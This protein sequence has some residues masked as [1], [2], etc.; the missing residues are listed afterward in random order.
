[1]LTFFKNLKWP[2]RFLFA[3]IFG[4]LVYVVISYVPARKYLASKIPTFGDMATVPVLVAPSKAKEL[5]LPSSKPSDKGVPV[6]KMEMKWNSQMSE[7]LANGGERTTVGSSA[8]KFGVNMTLSNETEDTGRMRDEFMT[9][10]TAYAEAREKD[11]KANPQVGTH[12]FT[13]MGSGGAA[14]ASSLWDRMAKIGLHPE[15][16][17][18]SSGKSAGEDK[19]M[20]P[21]KWLDNPQSARGSL[22]AVFPMDGDQD[23]I[24]LWAKMNRIPV[25]TNTKFFDNDAINI[26]EVSDFEIAGKAY[27]T[28]AQ[29][30]RPLIKNG[31]PV[32]GKPETKTVEGF[33]SWTPVDV[34][35]ME[36][37]G[38]VVTLASTATKGFEWQMPN[39]TFG[40][41]E[42]DENHREVIEGWI[43]AVCEAGDQ[44]IKY[45][46]A[47][48]HA[49]KIAA[50]V[51]HAYDGA[52]WEKYYKGYPIKDQGNTIMLGG[53]A[54]F[55]LPMN[56]YMYGL[57]P[58]QR[59]NIYARTYTTFGQLQSEFY[60]DI[61][62]SFP[63]AE[64]IINTSYLNAVA[65]KFQ[66][67]SLMTEA[68]VPTYSQS[69]EITTVVAKGSWDTIH[70]RSGS[71]EFSP[72]TEA[73]LQNLL[74]LLV[75]GNQYVTIIGHTDNDG[76]DQFNMELGQMR[77]DA[78]KRWLE[79][80]APGLFKDQR[81]NTSS[82]G[83]R[84]PVANNA[85]I[86]GK[87]SNR[88]VEIILGAK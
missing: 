36:K 12:F 51:Y 27:I 87:A 41:K 40:V 37:K 38:G 31:V 76:S 84:E 57:L 9:F 75:Q 16:I 28:G 15:I 42:W 54:T 34:T 70:F 24:F 8:E 61:L 53:S 18:F 81:I 48:H 72:E 4:V 58:E 64:Q 20:G 59:L 17:A 82:R 73:V 1:M 25:N 30:T 68:S 5:P 83:M 6:R 66:D 13:I 49:S 65:S 88:R 10:A 85:T 44:V 80:H 71:A 86:S 32:G 62:K 2:G 56:L 21:K 14:M 52:Y 19:F 77:A 63:S 69:G 33:S 60:P 39:V 23:I 67:G 78:V 79:A 50:D 35:V 43:A 7:K 11:P 45:P 74:G 26:Y 3:V 55:N 47:L 29:D 22:V 46:N